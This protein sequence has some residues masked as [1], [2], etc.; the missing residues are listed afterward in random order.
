MGMGKITP[1][2]LSQKLF[3]GTM[4]G[5]SWQ[6]AIAV[7]IPT[8]GGYQLD[9]HFKTSPYLTLVGLTLAVIGSVLIIRKALKDLNVY[10]MPPNA[11]ESA[12]TKALK[13][14]K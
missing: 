1:D 11:A 9:N 7:L 13:S 12:E 8:V 5:M 6:M 4:L 3:V 14:T 10:M 2:D